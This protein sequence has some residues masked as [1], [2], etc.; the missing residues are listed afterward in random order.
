MALI[1]KFGCNR[2]QRVVLL[3]VILLGLML[4]GTDLLV[5]DLVWHE[6]SRGWCLGEFVD[7]S[8]VERQLLVLI[9]GLR[10]S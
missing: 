7:E 6:G 8:R 9:S 2:M 3:K 1:P 10:C 4:L 5:G